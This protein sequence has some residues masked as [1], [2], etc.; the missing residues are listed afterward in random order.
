[1]QRTCSVEPLESVAYFS[2]GANKPAEVYL[3]ENIEK[4][5]VE[6]P[7]GKKTQTQYV[8]DEVAFKTM[9]SKEEV[10]ENFDALWVKAETEAKPLADR[11]DE[12]EDLLGIVIDEML[13]VA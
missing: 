2:H 6:T 3:R 5:D 1:M 13:E 11:I 10:E 12:I 4:V 9:L 7:D 8:A